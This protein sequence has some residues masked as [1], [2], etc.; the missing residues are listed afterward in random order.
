VVGEKRAEEA[1]TAALD[2]LGE[3]DIAGRIMDTGELTHLNT[4]DLQS[5]KDRGEA[6]LLDLIRM[7]ER[8]LER[9]RSR[10]GRG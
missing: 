6:A 2:R 10:G 4:S 5:V 7:R 9:K 3:T 8:E 1:R